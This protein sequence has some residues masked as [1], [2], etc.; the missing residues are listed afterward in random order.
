MAYGTDDHVRKGERQQ[1]L[2]RRRDLIDEAFRSL[3]GA[4]GLHDDIG[5]IKSEGKLEIESIT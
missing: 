3:L 1:P 5:Y 2:G 4:E